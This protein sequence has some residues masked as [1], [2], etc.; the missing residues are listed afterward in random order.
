[1]KKKYKAL[2]CDF[3]WT[4]LCTEIGWNVLSYVQWKRMTQVCYS[5]VFE[6]IGVTKFY[7]NR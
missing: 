1:M 6:E 5:Q 7:L 2:I 3:S 4:C